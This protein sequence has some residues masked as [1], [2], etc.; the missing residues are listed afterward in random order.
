MP[1][2]ISGQIENSNDYVQFIIG[3]RDKM[4]QLLC[5]SIMRKINVVYEAKLL[6]KTSN[7]NWDIYANRKTWLFGE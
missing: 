3:G 5:L 6:D 7:Y 2:I 4:K 1:T